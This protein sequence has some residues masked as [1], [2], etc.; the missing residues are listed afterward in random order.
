MDWLLSSAAL[1]D[2]NPRAGRALCAASCSPGKDN[3]KLKHK[4]TS[5]LPSPKRQ[6][7]CLGN[8][9]LH[10]LPHST[11]THGV[12]KAFFFVLVGNCCHI[13]I[14]LSYWAHH[15]FSL[16]IHRYAKCAWTT[17]SRGISSLLFIPVFKSRW[18]E[19]ISVTLAHRF[20]PYPNNSLPRATTQRLDFGKGNITA[21]RKQE[22]ANS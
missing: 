22:A 21:V 7:H 14:P 2:G 17:A 16:K 15:I 11:C 8:V 5:T 20:P 3:Q 4:A 10:P 9:D 13:I 19:R 1:T 12:A 6:S 18:P